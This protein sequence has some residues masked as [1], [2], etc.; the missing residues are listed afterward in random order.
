MYLIR[1]S[2]LAALVFLCFVSFDLYSQTNEWGNTGISTWTLDKVSIGRNYDFAVRDIHIFKS[3]GSVGDGAPFTDNTPGIRLESEDV[4]G[5]NNIWDIY[6]EGINGFGIRKYDSQGGF[7]TALRMWSGNSTAQLAAQRAGLWTSDSR[8]NFQI[9]DYRP[10]TF[11]S[12]GG[13]NDGIFGAYIGF[14]AYLGQPVDAPATVT[15]MDGNPGGSVFVTDYYGNVELQTFDENSSS[16][17]T[18]LTYDPQ[19]IFSNKGSLEFQSGTESWT[20]AH[21]GVVMKSE[22]GTA[23][24]TSESN[25][26][27][28]HMGIGMTNSGWFFIRS[29]NAPGGTDPIDATCGKYPF[30]VTKDGKTVTREVEVNR[31]GWCDY[32]FDDSYDLADLGEVEAFIKQNKHLPGV[33]SEAQVVNEGLQ[34]GEMSAIQMKKIEELTLYVIELQ[35]NYEDLQRQNDQL[36]TEMRAGRK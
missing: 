29:N 24:V 17:V 36:R 23:W 35:K 13:N 33:P 10:I 15:K 4:F 31:S 3:L 6:A 7:L 18:G 22:I 5:D 26:N 20:D 1:T 11:S 19:F 25:D 28:E 2:I 32:V 8:T 12:T 14:N 27:D 34:L 30:Y 16:E 9:G 21:W